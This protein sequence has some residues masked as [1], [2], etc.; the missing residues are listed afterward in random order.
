MRVVVNQARQ[1][2]AAGGV[3]HLGALD[4]ADLADGDDGLTVDQDVCLEGLTCVDD[5]TAADDLLHRFSSP[6][7]GFSLGAI[8]A[9]LGRNASAVVGFPRYAVS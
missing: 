6:G 2:I 8:I 4:V 1:Q 9:A 3:D 7:Q 5:G